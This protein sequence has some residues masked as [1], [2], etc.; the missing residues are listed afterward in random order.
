MFDLRLG[1]DQVSRL[2]F[3][4]RTRG[5]AGLEHDLLGFT[6]IHW[7]YYKNHLF[8]SNHFI[9]R[10]DYHVLFYR[11]GSLF[12]GD[13]SLMKRDGIPEEQVAGNQT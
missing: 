3:Y 12:T 10:I 1:T 8:Y 9:Y 6:V 11:Y 4:I 5:S 2:E 13:I 7:G